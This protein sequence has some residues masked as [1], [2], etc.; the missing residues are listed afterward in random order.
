MKKIMIT[1][2]KWQSSWTPWN[3]F[4]NAQ[5]CLLARVNPV[6]S[7]KWPPGLPPNQ[8]KNLHWHFP[9]QLHFFRTMMRILRSLYTTHF[10]VSSKEFKNL[11]KVA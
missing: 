9:V 11:I 10:L 8:Q 6:D 1:L 7:K 3:F 4:Q 5:G 2:V